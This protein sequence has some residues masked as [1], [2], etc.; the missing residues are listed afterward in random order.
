M[1]TV[2]ELDYDKVIRDFANAMAAKMDQPKNQSK[3][4]WRQVQDH[5]LISQLLE[6][7]GELCEAIIIGSDE[8]IRSE[9]YDVANFAMMIADRHRKIETV[10]A[11]DLVA[12]IC[13]RRQ[14]VG[15][16]KP[17]HPFKYGN[18]D[19]W[20]KDDNNT[21]SWCGSM[22][23]DDFMEIA[24]TGFSGGG[25]LVPTDK[26]YKVYAGLTHYK[27]YFMHLSEVQQ[28]EFERLARE[29]LLNIASPGHFY[30]AP[31]FMRNK[32]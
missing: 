2:A 5:V 15:A 20:R 24:K 23:P 27:F 25:Q 9:C 8:D 22:H 4:S 30:V 32:S 31:F 16:D 28:I 1:T 21:C 11:E 7:A 3:P 10:P 6:E 14:E 26:S 17:G 19:H 18:E 29:G 13:P 12:F